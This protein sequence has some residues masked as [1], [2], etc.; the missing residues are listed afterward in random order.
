MTNAKKDTFEIVKYIMYYLLLNALLSQQ[1][2]YTCNR[3][4]W[5]LYSEVCHRAKSMC[6]GL[7]VLEKILSYCKQVAV[8]ILRADIYAP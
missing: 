2:G 1:K 7:K 6:T 5:V 3:I 4:C 8:S